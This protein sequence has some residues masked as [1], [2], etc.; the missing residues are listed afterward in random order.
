MVGAMP[1]VDSAAPAV[2][3]LPSLRAVARHA[4]PGL[5]ESTVGPGVVFYLVLVVWGFRGALLAGLGWSLAAAARRLLRR[6]GMSAL[7]GLS[8]V[9]LA[10]RTVIAFATG[11]AFFYFVQPTAATAAVAV[12]FLVSAAV[13]RPFIE[14]L[15]H[16]FCPL[17]PEV[18]SRPFV[19]RFFLRL[20]VLW[21]VV[22]LVNAGIVLWL[23]VASSLRAFVVQ[24]TLVTWTLT[25]GG[26]VLST[27]WFCRT[28]RG[29]GLSVRFAAARLS[30]P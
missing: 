14:R 27:L 3:E 12:V 9:L 6:Q 28:M 18:M 20:S 1:D 26:V 21:A 8:L 19:R 5:L 15:A 17:D 22:L 2:I 13:R 23:L 4:L 25:A 10:V 29:A 30:A 7:L 11:S 24:R 16:E